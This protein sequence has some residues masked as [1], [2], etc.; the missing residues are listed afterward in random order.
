MDTGNPGLDVDTD[1][2]QAALESR[3]GITVYTMAAPFGALDYVDIARTRYLINRGTGGGTIAANDN[4]D[5]FNL[6]CFIPNQ[7]APVGD[8]NAKVDGVRNTGTWQTVLVH[9]F[10]GAAPPDD[11]YNPVDLGVFQQAVTYA[12]SFGD[13]W[14][15]RVVDVASYWRGQAAFSKATQTPSGNGTTFAWALPDHFPPGKFL[16]VSVDGGTLTQAGTPLAWNDHG[17]YE[18]ALDEGAVTLSP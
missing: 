3:F 2:G 17:Y 16:R 8:F 6:P 14:I 10:N 1:A 15:D 11:A 13:I 9:G 12:K 5:P 18:V 7:D 4:T